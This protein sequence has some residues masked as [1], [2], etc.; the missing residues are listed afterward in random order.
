VFCLATLA[1]WRVF[2]VCFL[3]H[4]IRGLAYGLVS[5]LVGLACVFG[6]CEI[7]SKPGLPTW[8]SGLAE[9]NVTTCLVSRRTERHVYFLSERNDMPTF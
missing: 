3:A 1:R 8:L 5:G 2:V 4:W 9:A 7:H 6:M